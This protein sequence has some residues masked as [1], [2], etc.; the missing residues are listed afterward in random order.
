MM[1]HI[2][3]FYIALKKKKKKNKKKKKKKHSGF[4][5]YKILT[6]FFWNFFSN[7]SSKLFNLT[8]PDMYLT[9]FQIAGRWK[10]FFDTH[11]RKLQ[12]SEGNF[13][14]IP[15]PK[16]HG[17]YMNSL[18]SFTNNLTLGGFREWQKKFSTTSGR[19]DT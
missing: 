2:I 17:L 16:A 4:F 8:F 14:W 3:L 19:M 7:I 1:Y 10:L 5:P 18:T 11:F 15:L 9:H 12:P 13:G 6:E